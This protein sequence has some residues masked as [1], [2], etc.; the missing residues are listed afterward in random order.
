MARIRETRQE[1]DLSAY[2]MMRGTARNGSFYATFRAQGKPTLTSFGEVA[3]TLVQK[4]IDGDRAKVSLAGNLRTTARI[5]LVE[6]PV[7]GL[8][9]REDG[10][11]AA[12]PIDT[13]SQLPAVLPA[14]DEP[15]G[16]WGRLREGARDFLGISDPE[17]VPAPVEPET[18]QARRSGYPVVDDL[19]D[20]IV[21]EVDRRPDLADDNGARFDL[22]AERH[23]FA[24]AENHAEAVR[25]ASR[26]DVKRADGLFSEYLQ[27]ADSSLT[28]AVAREDA[29]E[30]NGKIDRLSVDLAFIRT[31]Q[32]IE[33]SEKLKILP[34]PDVQLP[35]TDGRPPARRILSMGKGPDDHSLGAE[36]VMLH[37]GR[38]RG[39]GR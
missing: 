22:L 8:P 24:M 27:I 32:G 39:A 26:S 18:A 19:I 7:T 13:G 9:I 12:K 1:I 37:A 17:P 15:T 6:C 16:F 31:R 30:R 11:A 2:T 33:E 29:A 34:S 21:R 10:R 23:L 25:G 35:S 28:D 36:V 20:R 14:L 3:E 5:D 4:A 38:M